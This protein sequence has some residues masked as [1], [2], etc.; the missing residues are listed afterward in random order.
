M[1]GRVQD[2]RIRGFH[3][4]G[5]TGRKELKRWILIGLSDTR[6]QGNNAG[7]LIVVAFVQA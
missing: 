4:R 2:T 5:A 3:K 1:G 7:N 6:V